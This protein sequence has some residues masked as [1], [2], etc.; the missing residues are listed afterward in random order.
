[1]FGKNLCTWAYEGGSAHGHVRA[2]VITQPSQNTGY[3]QCSPKWRRREASQL[4]RDKIV[5][6]T[7]N[8]K[9]IP[10]LKRK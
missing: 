9:N 2:E 6:M 8:I 5:L 7:T 4:Y 1:M 3:F 10:V